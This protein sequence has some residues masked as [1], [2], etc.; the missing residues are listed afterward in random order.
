MQVFLHTY[1]HPALYLH[2]AHCYREIWSYIIRLVLYMVVLIH[3]INKII[4]KNHFLP[5]E[6]IFRFMD[7]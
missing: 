6:S 7:D 4:V 2:S 3:F 5:A 1:I